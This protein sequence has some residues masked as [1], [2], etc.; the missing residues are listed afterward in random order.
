MVYK[1]K[2]RCKDRCNCGAW[3]NERTEKKRHTHTYT[4]RRLKKNE[5]ERRQSQTK[6]PPQQTGEM[7]TVTKQTERGKKAQAGG[8]EG[9]E[10]KKKKQ[11]NSQGKR[12]KAEPKLSTPTHPH[13]ERDQSENKSGKSLNKDEQNLG[14]QRSTEAQR[15][16]HAT[17]P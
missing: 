13:R 10:A 7:S 3:R 12:R 4:T 6:E 11:G 8:E 1:E 16:T 17:I 15:C 14:S 9:I 5:D 2:R